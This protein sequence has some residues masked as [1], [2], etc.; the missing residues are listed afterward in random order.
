M[1]LLQWVLIGLG[2]W[3]VVA[4]VGALVLAHLVRRNRPDTL[5]V[6]RARGIV[7][8]P[9]TAPDDPRCATD[10]PS[11][12]DGAHDRAEAPSERRLD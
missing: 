2:A 3:L 4:V 7:D 8:E 6:L 5:D 9:E 1:S 12:R 10:L 11:P